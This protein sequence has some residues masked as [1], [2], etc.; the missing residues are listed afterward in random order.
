MDKRETI[1]KGNWIKLEKIGTWEFASRVKGSGAVVIP[2]ITKNEEYIFVEQFRPAVGGPVIEWPA[3][4][5]ADENEEENFMDAGVRE[6]LEETGYIPEECVQVPF[7]VYSSPGMTNEYS[8]YLICLGCI[9]ENNGGG[10]DGEDI[11]VHIISKNEFM[12]WLETQIELGKNIS[13]N[14]FTG[15]TLIDASLNN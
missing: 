8:N 5:V 13:S 2:N 6:L 15:M 12:K 3:G 1:A 9:K 7:K 10:V 4:I 11:K 14:I